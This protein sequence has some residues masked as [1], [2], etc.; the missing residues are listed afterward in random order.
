[1]HIAFVFVFVELLCIRDEIDDI[2]LPVLNGRFSGRPARLL[3]RRRTNP[4]S[5]LAVNDRVK[6]KIFNDDAE[7]LKEILDKGSHD[8]EGRGLA[9]NVLTSSIEDC[10]G[11][12]EGGIEGGICEGILGDIPPVIGGPW[13]G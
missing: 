2:I 10:W 5:L 11:D 13:G 9:F 3:S 4:L 12:T 6:I 7:K 1:L 8:F